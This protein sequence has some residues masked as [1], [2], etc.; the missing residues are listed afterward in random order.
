[1]PKIERCVAYTFDAYSGGGGGSTSEDR[2]NSGTCTASPPFTP[3][4]TEDSAAASPAPS[5]PSL[6]EDDDEEEEEEGE[7]N[8]SHCSSSNLPL[9]DPSA[10]HIDH[11]NTNMHPSGKYRYVITI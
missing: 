4:G 10:D 3:A 2:P 11:T 8:L 6:D 7:E 5:I 1:M 9:P